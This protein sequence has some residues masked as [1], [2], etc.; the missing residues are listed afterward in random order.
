M[1]IA[2][3]LP[4]HTWGVSTHADPATPRPL[5]PRER[6]V[7]DALL[8]EDFPGAPELRAQVASTT[9][10]GTCGCGCPT[11]YLSVGATT[12]APAIAARV[13]VGAEVSDTDGDS[14]LLFADNGHLSSLEYAW[15]ERPP[16][17]FPEADRLMP[18]AR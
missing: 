17:E 4:L 3:A 13:P 6:A 15:V 11:V 2:C 10:S 16:R 14:V 8:R 18:Q 1:P 12:A 5:T 7:L 9:V